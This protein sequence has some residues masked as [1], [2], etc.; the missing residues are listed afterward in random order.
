MTGLLKLATS[1]R[2][3]LVAASLFATPG[4]AACGDDGG[5]SGGGD[6]G[7]VT[8]TAGDDTAADGTGDATGS[9]ADITVPDSGNVALYGMPAD[10][11]PEPDTAMDTAAD[12]VDED[13]TRAAYGMPPDMFDQPDAVEDTAADVSEEVADVPNM[14]L[15][16]IP[17]VPDTTG[18]ASDASDSSD[19]DPLPQPVYGA[20]PPSDA[21]PTDDTSD[22]SDASDA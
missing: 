20:P 2:S 13:L 1:S 12:V 5:D 8:D 9:D 17:P 22:A 7:A 3:A 6:T 19:S 18:D 14:A 11:G 10:M 16:G 15:Y 4:L 21:G